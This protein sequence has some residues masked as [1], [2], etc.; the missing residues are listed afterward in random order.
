MS[1]TVTDPERPAAPPRRWAGLSGRAS[2]EAG[3][4]IVL[5]HGLTFDHRM[6]EPALTALG[7][8]QR[9][10]AFD[11]PGHGASPP[12]PEAGLWPVV[13]AVHAAV[14]A[15]GLEAPLVVGHSIGG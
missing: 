14:R 13:A 3:C 11:L 10:I 12:L 4:P 2:G 5:L 8:A 7:G 6:W 15:A 1:S 9:A